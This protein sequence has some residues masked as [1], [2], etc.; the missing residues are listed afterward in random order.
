MALEL[1]NRVVAIVQNIL[2]AERADTPSWLVRPGKVECGSE[3]ERISCIYTELTGLTLPEVMRSVER[4]TVDA[5]LL[6]KGHPPRI[7]EVDEKQHFNEFRAATLKHY[8]NAP[9]AF[10]TNAW[11]AASVAKK[12]LEGGGFAKAKPPLFSG[13]N[14]RHL[15]R[16]FRDALCD[17]IPPLHGFAPTL[18]IADFEVKSWIYG[19]DAEGRMHELLSTRLAK[20]NS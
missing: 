8:G 20:L 3:W 13:L 4:R 11:L 19:N 10:D 12:K 18:R 1:Q 7:L 17:L 16:A 2:Q 15:Q 5:V 14:G 9:V 6:Q